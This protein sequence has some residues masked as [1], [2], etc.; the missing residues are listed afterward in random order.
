MHKVPGC[1][2]AYLLCI[3]NS[4]C[5]CIVCLRL[6]YWHW[7]CNECLSIADFVW[8]RLRSRDWC[9]ISTGSATTR[10]TPL[11]LRWRQGSTRTCQGLLSSRSK[12]E[13]S[14]AT[15]QNKRSK[16]QICTNQHV[17][18]PTFASASQQYLSTLSKLKLK[19]FCWLFGLHVGLATCLHG[20]NISHTLHMLNTDA[21]QQHNGVLFCFQTTP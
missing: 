7:H 20:W 10:M 16:E 4:K 2:A 11:W 12:S 15:T 5:L 18:L 19:P 1:L 21:V 14:K 6:G 13:F 8:F 9:G 17:L 3:W